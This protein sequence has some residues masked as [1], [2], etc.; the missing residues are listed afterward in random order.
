MFHP[1]SGRK[2]THPA[3]QQKN[4]KIDLDPLTFI[5]R[6]YGTIIQS[7]GIAQLVSGFQKE[8]RGHPESNRACLLE[9]KGWYPQLIHFI[10]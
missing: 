2:V 7:I 5:P 6:A 4:A 3:P 10:L 9:S 1:T 8:Y